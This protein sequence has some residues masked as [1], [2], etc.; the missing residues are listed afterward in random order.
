MKDEQDTCDFLK[1]HRQYDI[2]QGRKTEKPID[3]FAIDLKHKRILFIQYKKKGWSML[4]PLINGKE[5]K[6][7]MFHVKFEFR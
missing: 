1:R 4:E 3:I 7:S 2:V 5:G 6:G